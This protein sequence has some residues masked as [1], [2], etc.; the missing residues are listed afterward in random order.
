VAGRISIKQKDI[1]MK[2]MKAFLFLLACLM[3]LG[4]MSCDDPIPPPERPSDGGVI[5]TITGLDNKLA[6]LQTNARSG[7]SY[8]LE[9]NT[10]ESMI[11]HSLSYSGRSNITI[12]IRGIGTN[13]TINIMPGPTYYSGFGVF[14]GVTL[15]L[16]NIAL[17]GTTDSGHPLVYVGNGATLRMNAGSSITG[18]TLRGGGGVFVTRG[19]FIMNGGI[20]SGN[21]GGGVQVENR[22]TFTMNGGTISGNTGNWGGGVYIQNGTFTMNGGTISGN[23]ANMG[24]GVRSDSD[25]N[26]TMNGGFISGNTAAQGGGVCGTGFTMRGG[27]ISGNTATEIGGGVYDLSQGSFIKTG[28]TIYGHG[29]GGNSNIATGRTLSGITR[30]GHAVYVDS[31]PVGKRRDTTAGVG[32]NLDARV[33]GAA[34]GWEN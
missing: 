22:G 6:W 21:I 15:V 12:T 3:A 24:G 2:Y 5:E 28:G 23:T 27:V 31:W 20:I 25:G 18:N 32:V 4:L 11:Y 33:A 14:S 34:G 30:F 10:N 8:V 26:F 9:V 29:E 19:T 13:R 16:D 1:Q 17:H 7:G